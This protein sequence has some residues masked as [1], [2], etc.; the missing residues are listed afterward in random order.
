MATIDVARSLLDTQRPKL[1]RLRQ[2]NIVLQTRD[3]MEFFLKLQQKEDPPRPEVL[4]FVLS[5]TRFSKIFEVPSH[6]EIFHP[7]PS[8]KFPSRPVPSRNF[9]SRPVPSLPKISRPVPYRPENFRPVP[10]LFGTGFDTPVQY[11]QHQSL[12]MVGHCF[13]ETFQKNTIGF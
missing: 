4:R 10:S 7:V 1:S 11:M 2:I 9:S 12:T 3:H 8:R 13:T 6:P 5:Q